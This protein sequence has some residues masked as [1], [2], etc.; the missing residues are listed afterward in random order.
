MPERTLLMIVCLSFLSLSL[1]FAL[2]T[3]GGFRLFWLFLAWTWMVHAAWLFV[4]MTA[5][6]R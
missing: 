3:H 2:M 4:R 1:G 6:V 5:K